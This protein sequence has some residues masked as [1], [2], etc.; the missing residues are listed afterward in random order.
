[1]NLITHERQSVV[2][3]FHITHNVKAAKE[4]YL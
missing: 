1:M 4:K 2:G 3:S